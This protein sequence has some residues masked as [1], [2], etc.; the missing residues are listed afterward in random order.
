M[1]EQLADAPMAINRTRLHDER[2]THRMSGEEE[3][4]SIRQYL[5]GGGVNYDGLSEYEYDSGD[6][7]SPEATQQMIDSAL[8]STEA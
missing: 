6:D 7:V 5:S 4:L 2:M 3:A 1:R 8:R